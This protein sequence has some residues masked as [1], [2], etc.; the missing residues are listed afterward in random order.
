MW[1][2]RCGGYGF[3][4]APFGSDKRT[5]SLPSEALN[6]VNQ[7]VERMAAG[8]RGLRSRACLSRTVEH[9]IPLSDSNAP[10]RQPSRQPTHSA[11]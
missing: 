10:R 2:M 9:S 6:M 4:A 3:E 1:Y 5:G 11:P 8:G 7:S